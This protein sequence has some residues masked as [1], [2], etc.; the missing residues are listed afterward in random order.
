LQQTYAEAGRYRRAYEALEE[1]EAL[2]SESLGEESRRAIAEMQAGFE[3]AE[4]EKAIELLEKDQALQRA[5]LESQRILRRGLLGGFGLLLAVLALLFNRYRL[6]SREAHMRDAVARER[7]AN[8]RLRQVDKLKDEFLANTSH[9]LRT[10]LYGMIGLVETLL[11]GASKVAPEARSVLTTVLHSG[12]RLANLVADILDFSKLRRQGLE[13]AFE[14]VELH[15]L[16]DVVLTLAKPLAADRGLE[17][18]NAV[19]PGLPAAR[20]DEARVQQILHN[21][22][23]NAVKFTHQGRV[24]LSVRLDGEELEVRV[25]DTGIGIAPEHR[26]KIFESFAQADATTEREYGGT[27]LGLAVSRQ[28]VELHGGRLAVESEPGRGSVFSFTLP[29]AE[30]EEQEG[31]EPRPATAAIKVAELVPDE[32]VS[33]AAVAPPVS[34]GASG[35]ILMVDDEP[36]VRQVLDRHLAPRGYRLLS[37]ADGR[38]ALEILDTEE[39]D[40][41]LLDVMMPRM[42]GYQVCR[43]I[44][45][46]RS[47]DELPVIFLSARNRDTDRV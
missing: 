24:E 14:P 12:R 39:I 32:A 38:R 26:E 27:G 21:L 11:D 5:E 4:R 6:K 17:L 29:V 3:A 1:Y 33:E 41:V 37:A 23:G 42:S 20:A 40:L 25:A 30:G 10:P 35:T 44:R 9:E 31:V 16:A 36:V 45:E 13:L 22:V 47:R 46:Q 2:N 28:L 18:V 34:N 19:D 43:T 8:Q 7:E 15:A